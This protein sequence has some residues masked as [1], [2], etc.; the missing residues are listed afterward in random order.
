MS[1]PETSVNW[2]ALPIAQSLSA[3]FTVARTD[4][5]ARQLLQLIQLFI[6]VLLRFQNVSC[7][8]IS[9]GFAEKT[10][11]SGSV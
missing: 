4:T 6:V 7:Q 11:V 9:V 8:S 5:V 3:A 2:L 10:S 1:S